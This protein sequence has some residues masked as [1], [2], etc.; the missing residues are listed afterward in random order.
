MGQKDRLNEM[1]PAAKKA[2]LG[3]KLDAIITLVNE[4]KTADKYRAF[5]SPG[6][7][8]GTTG[9]T[10]VKIAN[11]VVYLNNGVFC[12]KT[13]A[14]VAFTATTHDIA[15]NALTVR[16][17]CYLIT[18]AANGTPTITKGTTATG[19]GNATVPA[20]PSGGTPIGYVRIAVAAGALPFDATTDA[21]NAAHL[22]VTYVNSASN[23]TNA[24]LTALA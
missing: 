18:L 16:E 5:T 17:A 9:N 2:A 19:A 7:A 22:T 12:S 13:P 11:T 20:T 1:C 15:P 23:L 4:M 6:L 3:T 14:E 24:N 10:A 21:L 8:I